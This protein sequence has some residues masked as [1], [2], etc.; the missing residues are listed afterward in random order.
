M[1]LP[2]PSAVL[3]LSVT[4]RNVIEEAAAVISPEPPTPPFT[5]PAWCTVNHDGDG[6]LKYGHVVHRATE[7]SPLGYAIEFWQSVVHSYKE[8]VEPVEVH[9]GNVFTYRFDDPETLRVVSKD[10]LNIADKLEQLNGQTPSK[11][12]PTRRRAH[13]LRKRRQSG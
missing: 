12:R 4:E 1:L 6:Y 8:R 10:L 7:A 5:C 11:V 2:Q 13:L 3:C 9:L